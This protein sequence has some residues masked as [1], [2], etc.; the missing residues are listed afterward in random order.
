[1]RADNQV[2]LILPQQL[3]E[4]TGV[5][6]I[7][8]EPAAFVLPGLQSSLV[9]NQPGTSGSLLTRSMYAFEKGEKDFVGVIEHIKCCTSCHRSVS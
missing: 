6:F 8:R 3:N 7:E 2:R 1:M 5:E 9:I 4:R